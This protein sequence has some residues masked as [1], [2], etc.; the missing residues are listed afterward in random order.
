[1][2]IVIIK[3]LFSACPHGCCRAVNQLGALLGIM[4]PH[5]R[6][7]R[8][9]KQN[10]PRRESPMRKE[11]SGMKLCFWGLSS[12]A[13]LVHVLLSF[14]CPWLEPPQLLWAI[15]A[16][17]DHPETHLCH[18]SQIH[19]KPPSTAGENT[20]KLHQGCSAWILGRIP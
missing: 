15:C 12:P 18:L 14:G 4:A 6:K 19:P 7:S 1:M 3:L 8:E 2:T 11:R 13:L 20:F 16:S 9:I 10:P 17:Q 5:R